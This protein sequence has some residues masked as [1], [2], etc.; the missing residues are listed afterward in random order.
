MED[1]IVFVRG[2]VR[3]YKFSSHLFG[4]ILS[5]FLLS[6]VRLASVLA[7]PQYNRFPFSSQSLQHLHEGHLVTL[8]IEAASYSE[9][10]RKYV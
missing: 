7:T 4:Q 1:D 2:P 5:R 9:T 10:P 6:Y 3:N 8:K